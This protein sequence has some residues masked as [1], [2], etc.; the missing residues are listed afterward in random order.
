MVR[1]DGASGKLMTEKFITF[2]GERRVRQSVTAPG[3]RTLQ[4][5]DRQTDG[6]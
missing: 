4:T 2:P 5:D 6:R 3:A 1:G